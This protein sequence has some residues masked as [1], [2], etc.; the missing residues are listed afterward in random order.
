M[1]QLPLMVRVAIGLPRQH[2]QGTLDILVLC[3]HRELLLHYPLLLEDELLVPLALPG[4]VL[5]GIDR[6]PVGLGLVCA[7]D[8]LPF[9]DGGG[10]VGALV[11]ELEELA[12]AASYPASVVAKPRQQCRG[13]Y[14]SPPIG[15]AQVCGA[16]GGAGYIGDAGLG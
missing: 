3:V 2:L 8:A 6:G 13:C 9:S 1:W 11:G 10:D 12:L 15:V 7:S 5:E 16:D 14:G 4:D